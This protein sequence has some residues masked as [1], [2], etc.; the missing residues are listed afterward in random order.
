MKTL[1]TMSGST[2]HTSHGIKSHAKAQRRKG[3]E[4]EVGVGLDFSVSFCELVV[5]HRKLYAW[6]R[7]FRSVSKRIMLFSPTISF[8]LSE[9]LRLCVFA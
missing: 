2:D 6:M 7:E 4:Q 1:A 5:I 3:S 8:A 9:P